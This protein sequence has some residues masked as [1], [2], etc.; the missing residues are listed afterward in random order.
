LS[1]VEIYRGKKTPNKREVLEI[2]Q[3]SVQKTTKEHLR[4]Q[5][6]MQKQEH[7]VASSRML[8]DEAA[9]SR[10]AKETRLKR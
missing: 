7:P 6:Y 2:I 3:A 5:F 8:L 4:T 10:N 9:G 1:T